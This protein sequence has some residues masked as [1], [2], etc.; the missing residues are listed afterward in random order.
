MTASHTRCQV[1]SRMRVALC[2]IILLSTSLRLRSAL[3]EA[4]EGKL[5]SDTA[6]AQPTEETTNTA[7]WVDSFYE[8]AA[9]LLQGQ[10]T[11]ADALFA[12]TEREKLAI[13][14]SSF[15]LKLNVEIEYNEELQVKFDPDV[16]ADLYL[17]NLERR[18]RIFVDTLEPGA[19]PG[20]SPTDR[21]RTLFTGLGR[22]FH[23]TDWSKFDARTGV[24][25]RWPPIPFARVEYG[26]LL[27]SDR[28]S[29][30]PRQRVFWLSD[31]GFGE[32]TV[33]QADYWLTRRLIA[34]S[35]T[36]TTWS[37]E[38]RGLEWEQSISLGYVMKGN[39]KDL[40]HA[41]GARISA[42][43]HYEDSRNN[44]DTYRL[45]LL[46]RRPFFRD[47]MFIKFVPELE[48]VKDDD[49]LEEGEDERLIASFRV[50]LDIFVTPGE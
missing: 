18:W 32:T 6:N 29:L 45:A 15:E 43:G 11:R 48:W 22:V 3:D 2:C 12:E 5:V 30:F 40:R 14:N 47:W 38:S 44:V 26:H 1:Q 23:Q 36:A 21:V 35:D 49:K 37:E 25:W 24:K 4:L 10:V 27:R 19:L 33:L 16:S 42:F 34:R 31:D 8:W 28:W 50:G 41:L 46:Y 20:T 13:T 9:D 39:A 17:P 7:H